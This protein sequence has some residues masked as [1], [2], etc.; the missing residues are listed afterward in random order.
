M[1][2]IIWPQNFNNVHKHNGYILIIIHLKYSTIYKLK[3][4]NN[5]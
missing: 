1:Q 2:L 4:Y 5:Y 3:I